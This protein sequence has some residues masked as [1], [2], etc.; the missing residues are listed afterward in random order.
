ML[1][2]K[3]K[4]LVKRGRGLKA[5]RETLESLWQEVEHLFGGAAGITEARIPGEEREILADATTIHAAR[6]FTLSLGSLLR[7][8][9]Q[10]WLRPKFSRMELNDIADVRQWT[11]IVG[12]R[13]M[14]AINRVES[15][16]AEALRQADDCLTKFGVAFIFVDENIK[17]NRLRFRAFHPRSC[18]LDVNEMGVVDTV[19]RWFRLRAFEMVAEF[20]R[21]KC[22]PDI[23]RAMEDEPEKL[24]EVMHVTLPNDHP[25]DH[26]IRLSNYPVV[27]AYVDVENDY[28]IDEQGYHEMPWIVPRDGVPAGWKYGYS[29]CM[30]NLPDARMLQRIGDA[31]MDA[32]EYQLSPPLLAADNALTSAI[33]LGPEQISYYDPSRMNGSSRSPIEALQLGGSLP[34]G[35]EHQQE[36]REMIFKGFM[37][38]IMSLP[39]RSNMS[40]TEI[41]RRNEDMARIIGP[42]SDVLLPDYNAALGDRVFG[43]MMRASQFP[44]GPRGPMELQGEEIHFEYESPV[45]RLEAETEI[46]KMQEAI[47]YGLNLAQVD[48]AVL[49]NYD[50]DAIARHIAIEMRVPERFLKDARAA[51]AMRAQMMQ[52]AQ[53]EEQISQ[54]QG[55]AQAVREG[56]EAAGAVQAVAA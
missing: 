19:F 28:L 16:A 3:I 7:P 55:G 32:S 56:A 2:E 15:R 42:M 51:E 20:G 34:V 4:A 17:L 26:G 9:G 52:A 29:I 35:L 31:L 45:A 54:A 1:A 18:Y 47:S 30:S 5:G 48:P 12:D 46:L 49:Q 25:V 6:A 39:D 37:R 50:L 33:R 40:A 23:I 11:N 53:M 13:M 24:W 38:D 44:G 22:H 8:R 27:S 21:D 41:I 14:T 10:K 36:T 43:I